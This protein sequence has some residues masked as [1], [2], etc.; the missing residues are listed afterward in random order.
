MK[1]SKVEIWL[2]GEEHPRTFEWSKEKSL[3][4]ETGR[5]WVKVF[6]GYE[7][8]RN[9]VSQGEF[10][11]TFIVPRDKVSTIWIERVPNDCEP[12]K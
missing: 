5:N 8:I 6:L 3:D 9:D 2:E 11:D 1:I 7:R 10:V 12:G 4:I